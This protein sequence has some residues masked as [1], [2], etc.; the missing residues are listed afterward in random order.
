M[1]YNQWTTA[2]YLGPDTI[3]NYPDYVTRLRDE[4]GLNTVVLS[5]TGEMPD[6]VLSLSPFK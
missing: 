1:E 3:L 4:I 2:I 6:E 5:F